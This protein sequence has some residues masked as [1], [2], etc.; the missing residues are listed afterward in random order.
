[1]DERESDEKKFHLGWQST[2][3]AMGDIR[4]KCDRCGEYLEGYFF[5]DE[6]RSW[7]FWEEPAT[8]ILCA[9]CKKKDDAK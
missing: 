8:E 6:K 7:R 4:T 3:H 5:V 1:M 2:A 9:D